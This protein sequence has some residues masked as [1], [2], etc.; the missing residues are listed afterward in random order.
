MSS[1]KE[2][3]RMKKKY[4]F[5]EK[6]INLVPDNWRNETPKYKHVRI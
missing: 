3:W 2:K 6:I 4:M 1:Y 5:V